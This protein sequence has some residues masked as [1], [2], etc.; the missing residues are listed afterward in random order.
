MLTRRLRAMPIVLA[1]FLPVLSAPAAAAG[2]VAL[3]VGNAAC[4]HAPRL[5]N[6]LNDAGV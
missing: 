2:R 1:A 4:A 3:V 5:A 6:P